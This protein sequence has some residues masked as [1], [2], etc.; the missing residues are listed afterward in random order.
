MSKKTWPWID[1]DAE[2]YESMLASIGLDPRRISDDGTAVIKSHPGGCVVEW[3]EILFGDDGNSIP[4][5]DGIKKARLRTT[6]TH[7][8]IS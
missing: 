4:T 3:T 5:Q 2:R 8:V 6:I 1:N 7:E